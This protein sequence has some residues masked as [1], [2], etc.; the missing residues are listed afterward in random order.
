MYLRKRR[1][2]TPMRIRR[3]RGTSTP[4]RI[5]V[6]LELAEIF[7]KILTGCTATVFCTIT[8]QLVEKKCWFLYKQRKEQSVEM[9]YLQ[10]GAMKDEVKGKHCTE[11][12][13]V[14]SELDHP[15][16]HG[17]YW[18]AMSRD[19]CYLWRHREWGYALQNTVHW[20][21]SVCW[22]TRGIRKRLCATCTPT[23]PSVNGLTVS[24]ENGSKN[25]PVIWIQN[26]SPS[27]LI[28]FLKT[29][30]NLVVNFMPVFKAV[31]GLQVCERLVFA[32]M[33][34][35]SHLFL[36]SSTQPPFQS[37]WQ[38]LANHSLTYKYCNMITVKQ[39]NFTDFLLPFLF[40]L[41]VW[42][43]C[44]DEMFC[45]GTQQRTCLTVQLV[46]NTSWGA[47]HG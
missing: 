27:L 33:M 35:F 19:C 34:L 2:R 17:N 32:M 22:N 4:T 41:L 20:H 5:G 23:S 13:L 12:K 30:W 29:S 16:E 14:Y 44:S 31:T 21:V 39:A 24:A 15:K 18:H 10:F 38:S 6:K 25:W 8:V 1:T 36:C 40:T 37:L 26:L 46:L 47:K 7:G 42:F 45:L 9:N 11:T 3:T 43:C 28:V